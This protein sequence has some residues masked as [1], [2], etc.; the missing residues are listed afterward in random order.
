[1]GH[2]ESITTPRDLRDL[3]DAQ[4]DDLASEIRDF[5]IATCA[6]TGGHL[7]PNLGVVEL[8]MAIHRIFDSPRDR[9]VFD[10]GHQAYVHKLLTGRLAGLR[11]APPGG[12]RQRLPEPGRVRPRHRRELPRLDRA[13][14]RRRPGQG[15]RH[16]RRGPPRRRRHRRRRPHRRHG[17]GGAQQH[18]DRPRQPPRH[19]RQ[20]QRPLLHARPSAASPTRSPRCAP[21]RATSRSSTRS[22]GGSTPSPASA[23][24]RTT[25]ST[26]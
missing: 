25:S 13:V 10:T 14:L 9:V 8:T 24:R 7:G 4:L 15:L 6:R 12:R 19:R 1:M 16:P 17:L 20:R 18:R 5:L 2:L 21:T 23:T 3:S 11:P 26:R 22:S